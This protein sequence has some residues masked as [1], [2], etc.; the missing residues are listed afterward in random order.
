MVNKQ[1]KNN[2]DTTLFDS[3][4]VSHFYNT[5]LTNIYLYLNTACGPK[6]FLN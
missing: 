3:F 2:N 1:L 5:E 6:K 4:R